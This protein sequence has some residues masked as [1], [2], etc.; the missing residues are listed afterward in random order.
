MTVTAGATGATPGATSGAT[1]TSASAGA[2]PATPSTPAGVVTDATSKAKW[3]IQL[4]ETIYVNTR[5]GTGPG[6]WVPYTAVYVFNDGNAV[7]VR[8]PD[9]VTYTGPLAVADNLRRAGETYA[10]PT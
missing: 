8:E 2:T 3:A 9:R 1:S 4:S 6:A 10:D 5:L 7:L